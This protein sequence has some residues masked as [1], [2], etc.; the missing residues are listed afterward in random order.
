[1]FQQ[2]F[3]PNTTPLSP[4]TVLL[5]L[6]T[7]I[8]RREELA[9]SL[10]PNLVDPYMRMETEPSLQNV[11]LNNNMTMINFQKVS[12]Y[13]NIL[14]LLLLRSLQAGLGPGRFQE[15][16]TFPLVLRHTKIY[17]VVQWGVRLLSCLDSQLKKCLQDDDVSLKSNPPTC[18]WTTDFLSGFTSLARKSRFRAS[19]TRPSLPPLC[20]T[21]VLTVDAPRDRRQGV[22]ICWHSLL[23]RRAFLSAQ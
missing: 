21:R 13:F 19:V 18:W 16:F 22:Q 5:T 8:V 7:C 20:Y 15:N 11:V 1:M 9:L 2:R 14:V 17:V 23:P 12:N 4:N 6:S 10:R 3:E